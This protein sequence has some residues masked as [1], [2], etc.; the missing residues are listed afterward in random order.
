MKTGFIGL[1]HLGKAMAGH[2]ISEGVDLMVWNRTRSKGSD[3][4]VP[5]AETPAQLVQRVDRIVLNLFDS[6]AVK[7]IFFKKDGLIQGGL[8]DKIIIDTSTN[9]AEEVLFFHEILK[10]QRG[11]YLEAPVLGSVLPASRGE[12]T[13]LVSGDRTAYDGVLPLIQKIGHKI[14]FLEEPGRA[15]R[16]KLVNNHLL[17]TFMAAIAE[18]L[19]LGEGAGLSK[20]QILDVLQEG[21]GQSLVLTAKREKLL[22]NDFSPQFS[23]ALIHKDLHYLQDLARSVKKPLFLGSLAKELYGM[24]F[25]RD[26][27]QADF[28]VL[29]QILKGL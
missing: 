14:F 27:D 8:T 11:Q 4:G 13:V 10:S 25:N 22:K 2:L 17:G 12:L 26:Q 16:M 6:Q 21:A 28:S 24:T 5:V 7:S 9:H 19:V 29:Y 3:L 23:A 18:A 1:G 15:T 20:K